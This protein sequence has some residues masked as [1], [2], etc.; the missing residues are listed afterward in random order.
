MINFG[1]I[2]GRKWVRVVFLLFHKI[3]DD[4]L[5]LCPFELLAML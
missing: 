1:L 4:I 3:F 2:L 5:Y